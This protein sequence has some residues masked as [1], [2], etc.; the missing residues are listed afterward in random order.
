MTQ[1]EPT[2][3]EEPK[4]YPIITPM[5]PERFPILE[6][7]SQPCSIPISVEDEQAIEFMDSLLNE[8]DEE[9]A[10]L[11]AIQIG[12]PRAIFLLRNGV[13]KDGKPEN[14]V[15]INPTIVSVSKEQKNSG[16]ACLSLPGMG[17][18]FKRPKSVTLQY[19]DLNG[20][21]YTE[22]FTNFWSRAVMHEMDHLNG[23]LISKH[24]E[25]TI[26]KQPSRTSFGMRVTPQRRN[27]IEKRRA[28]N[29]RA[30]KTR[31]RMKACG[32]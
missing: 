20:Q 25:Q 27:V 24:L 5:D 13:G 9:A 14:N 19:F 15:Y 1:T 17:A 29:K 4:R 12:Y 7:S 18:R 31:R 26:A 3:Q 11:A 8:L 6:M 10:G 2:P 30:K 22:T 32:R 23:T 28:A 16:E 21:T